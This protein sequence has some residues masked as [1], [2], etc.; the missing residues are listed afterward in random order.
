M[1]PGW[2]SPVVA[3]RDEEL[4]VLRRAVIRARPGSGGMVLVT[5][6]AGIGMAAFHDQDPGEA[7]GTLSAARPECCARI[8]GVTCGWGRE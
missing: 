6:E 8:A 4:A 3:G 2:H 5:G 7:Y 1:G